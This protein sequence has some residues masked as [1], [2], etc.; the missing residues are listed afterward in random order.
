MF[1]FLSLKPREDKFR[2]ILDE[3]SVQAD[4]CARHLKTFLDGADPAAR[5]RAAQDIAQCKAAA[6]ILSLQ[7]TKELCRT[8]ITP[9]DREDIQ[10]LSVHLYRIPKTI[11]K[12]KDRVVMHRL[13]QTGGEFSRQADIILEQADV[14]RTTISEIIGKQ[15][16]KSIVAKA[17]AMDILEQRGDTAFG[18]LLVALYEQQGDVRDILLRKDLYDLLEKVVDAYRDVSAVA[19]Q[20]VL[21][22]N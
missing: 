20:I 19:L 9:F 3:M 15:D 5:D 22:H 17:G 10:A 6:K 16:A 12:I 11:E 14:L 2:K 21:K 4:D 8:Y 18:E 7:V 13:N 1:K